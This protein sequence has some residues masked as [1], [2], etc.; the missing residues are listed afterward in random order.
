MDVTIDFDYWIGV[1]RFNLSQSVG[2]K[3]PSIV[4]NIAISLN[5]DYGIKALGTLV[6]I[7]DVLV[8]MITTVCP[9]VLQR[10]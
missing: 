4:H 7:D 5:D 6:I 10:T 8:T 1:G 2:E 9:E 3:S